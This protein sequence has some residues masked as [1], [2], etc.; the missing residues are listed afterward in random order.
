M[1]E[2]SQRPSWWTTFPGVLTG[3]AA[4][5]TAVS[6][7]VVALHPFLVGRP[8]QPPTPAPA[9]PAIVL[10]NVPP[11]TVV[12]IPPER[13]NSAAG[14]S[15]V[16]PPP[17]EPRPPTPTAGT[18]S[19]AGSS[20]PA[21]V[22]GEALD[23]AGTSFVVLS[24]ETA[25]LQPGIREIRVTFRVTAADTGVRLWRDNVRVLAGGRV[26]TPVEGLPGTELRPGAVQQFWVRFAIQEPLR[27][28]ILSFTDNWS[29]P[30]GEARRALID[31]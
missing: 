13:R 4:L 19:P 21:L 24:V 30:R 25:T 14:G 3:I 26:H 1:A 6:G 11:P 28:P 18:T 12:P 29:T 20:V 2:P 8:E 10:P 16:R 23:V 31:L 27:N 7:L 17:T 22:L 9:P 5:L 15:E